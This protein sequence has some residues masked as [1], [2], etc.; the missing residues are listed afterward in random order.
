MITLTRTA[1]VTG[2]DLGTEPGG[3]DVAAGGRAEAVGPEQGGISDWPEVGTWP[4]G[5]SIETIP[6][7]WTE[8][9]GHY[10]VCQ[11]TQAGGAGQQRQ[12]E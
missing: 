9:G 12:P 10:G 11:A 2:R 6:G 3:D 7:Q 1:T 5:R 4:G 8:V